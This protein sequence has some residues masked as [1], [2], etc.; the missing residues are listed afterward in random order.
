[1][2]KIE[3]TFSIATE[4]DVINILGKIMSVGVKRKLDGVDL[5]RFVTAVSELGTNL[6]KYA[7]GGELNIIM[8]FDEK[9]CSS[10]ILST[11]TGPGIENVESAMK[12][13]FSTGD[14]L[15][16]GLTSCYRIADEFNIESDK[17]GTEIS[18]QKMLKYE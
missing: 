8:S 6:V 2:E 15:G 1:M 14:T 10:S 18:F 12:E 13:N 4:S 7:T 5:C 16:L 3:E 9:G 11:D 17:S